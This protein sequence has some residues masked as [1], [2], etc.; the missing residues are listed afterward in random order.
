MVTQRQKDGICS[1]EEVLRIRERLGTH[2]PALLAAAEELTAYVQQE[3]IPGVR[4]MTGGQGLLDKGWAKI[5]K[6]YAAIAQAK[7]R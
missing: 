5:I 6:A 1:A 2:G 3:L 4:E 7:G